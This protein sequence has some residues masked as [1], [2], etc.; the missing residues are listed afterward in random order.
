ME[1]I[2]I[3]ASISRQ[4]HFRALQ[5]EQDW[6]SKI[7][8]YSRFIYSVRQVHPGMGLRSIYEQ[9]QP[10]DVGRDAFIALGLSE[11]F[12][13]RSISNPKKTTYSVKSTRYKNLL[14]DK[15]L[16][17]FNQVWVSD[18]FYFQIGEK[19]YYVVLIMDVYSRRIVGYNAADNM[20]AENTVK[21]LQMALKNRGIK[22]FKN[23]LIHHSDRGSQYISN[24]YTDLL[25]SRNIRISM[26]KNVL[27]NAHCERANGT[28]KNDYLARKNITSFPQLKRELRKSIWA[29]NFDRHHQGLKPKMTP[30]DF[31]S[32]IK[33][34]DT[35]KRP[36]MTIFTYNNQISD[37]INQLELNFGS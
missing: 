33:E 17:N 9:H 14:I 18:L 30:V 31:E 24:T 4:G 12:R 3:T 15:R 28:I 7:D 13:L 20:R 10:E 32:Y 36:K 19:H 27:E 21:A 16:T 22:D 34:L 1:D 6:Q 25:E 8:L 5:R 23:Q 26:C 2:Y 29:Y 11:G 35:K 37:S